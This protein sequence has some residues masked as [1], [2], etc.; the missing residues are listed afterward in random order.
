M[1][2]GLYLYCR[3]LAGYLNDLSRIA[4]GNFSN[5]HSYTK[6]LTINRLRKK[7]GATVFIEAGTYR[8]VTAA[9][10]SSVFEKV[11]TIELDPNL[12]RAASIFLGNKR[13]VKVIQGDAVEVLHDLLTNH[14]VDR[15]LLFLDGHYSRGETACGVIPEPAAEE[16]QVLKNYR[17]KINAIVIDDVRSFGTEANFPKKSELL[18]S[19]EE[20]FGDGFDITLFLDQLIL[21]RK[22]FEAK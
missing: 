21:T 2:R 22:S 11:Y 14:E 17:D 18:R 19:A 5:P 8:G 1:L 6:F 13:N 15:V 12:A 10:C 3:G 9:R 20:S 7:T 16:L 4:R